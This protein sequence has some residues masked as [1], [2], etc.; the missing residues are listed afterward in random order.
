MKIERFTM[1]LFIFIAGSFALLYS[2]S[3]LHG[4]D[5]RRRLLCHAVGIDVEKGEFH[6]TA[7]IFKP[8]QPGSDTPVDITQTNVEVLDGRGK[9]I[10]QAIADC[11]RQRGKKLFL[12]HLKLICLGRNVDLSKPRDL[13][14]FCLGDKTVCLETDICFCTDMAQELLQTHMTTEMISTENYIN[15]LDYNAKTS[16]CARCRLIDLLGE[17]NENFTAL[18]P[19]LEVESKGENGKEPVVRAEKTAVVQ[20]GKPVRTLDAQRNSEAFLLL[21]SSVSAVGQAQVSAG[22]E[23]VMIE[24]C[25]L[26]KSMTI[27]DGK[28]CFKC[29]LKVVADSLGE[30]GGEKAEQIGKKIEEKLQA[31]FR[32]SYSGDRAQD[33]F[34][35]E[36]QLRFDLPRVYLN[37]KDN[38]QQ[39]LSK[40]KAEIEVVCMVK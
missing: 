14:G 23:A 7:Q 20:N 1:A 40:A 21:K 17:K 9:T 15:L 27:K 35:L 11:E 25:G 34:G 12:G 37:Y 31:A 16:R 36:K 22:P 29:S 5:L 24:K 2:S 28:L 38:I 33:I 8:S 13:F 10:P 6:I 26:K 39:Y 32:E 19:V 18:V 30:S 3:N 4:P